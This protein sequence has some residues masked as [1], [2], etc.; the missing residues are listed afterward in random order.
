MPRYNP[1]EIEPKW[2]RFWEENKTF[3]TPAMPAAEKLYVLD[4]FPYPSGS[5]LHVGHPEGYTATD[6]VCRFKR[7]RGKTVLHPMGF[8]AFGLPAEE[9][10]IKTNTPPRVSTEKN[11]AEFTR[12]LKML[13]FSYDWDRVLATTD[14]AYVRWTQWIFLVLFDTWF[15]KGQQ[16]GRPIAELPIPVDVRLQG[17][18][19]MAAYRDSFRLAYQD[20]ALVNWC[21][22]LGT[23]LAN[24][25]VIDGK[26]ERGDHPV[27]RIPL[28]QWMLRITAYAERLMADLEPLD[29]SPGIKKLQ[30]DWI[31]RSTGAEVDFYLGRLD[32]FAKWCIE[33]SRGGFPRL[34]SDDALRVSIDSKVYCQLLFLH[35]VVINLVNLCYLIQIQLAG[36]V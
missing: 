33:R 8:D 7:M 2:Q 34:P 32:G 11:I 19:A 5:G 6:I 23:V 25:E 20:D 35:H 13:G 27:Q 29:W 14:V 4:M 31:G 28:R 36:F 30:S 9:H 15:D 16:R 1:A 21:P 12:Q 3:Q 22:G 10:A 24:E 17:E 26:S 18:V